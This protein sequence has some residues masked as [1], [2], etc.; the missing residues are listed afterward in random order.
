MTLIAL[1]ISTTSILNTH[2]TPAATTLSPRTTLGVSSTVLEPA[3]RD[4]GALLPSIDLVTVWQQPVEIGMPAAV[5][6][7]R[8]PNA[9]ESLPLSARTTVI[10]ESSQGVHL[11]ETTRSYHR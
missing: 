8:V 6:P 7:P 11:I 2:D 5:T 1:L 9:F 10:I 4:R 3:D